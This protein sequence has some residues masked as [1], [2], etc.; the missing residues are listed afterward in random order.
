MAKKPKHKKG[1]RWGEK[2]KCKR[3]WIKYNEELVVRGEFLL[4]LD[5]VKSWDKEVQIMNEGKKGS[6]FQ[7]PESL[8]ELQAVWNQ[9]V[10]VRAIEGI[11]RKLV[12]VAEVPKFNDYSTVSRRIK[13]IKT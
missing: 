3:D 1:E 5:W 9:W 12:K 7:F 8:I 2:K 10:S 6:P 4:D 11:T 13:K